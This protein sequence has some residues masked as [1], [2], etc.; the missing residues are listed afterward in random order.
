LT[1]AAENRA[2]VLLLSGIPASRKTSFGRWLER[3]RGFVHLDVETPGVLERHG[4]R[5]EWDALFTQGPGSLIARLAGP[6]VI[7]WGFPPHCLPFV[8]SLVTAGVQPW[9]FGGDWDAAENSYAAAKRPLANFTRQKAAIQANWADIE[10]V[11]SPN[12]LRVIEPGP[13]FV[14]PEVIAQRVL[15]TA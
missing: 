4:L 1:R 11:F 12:V 2:K 8:R 9:W 7:D 10:A 3:E 5:P 15:G 13:T 6:T 14:G